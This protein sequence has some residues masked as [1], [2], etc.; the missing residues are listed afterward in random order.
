WQFR[1][2]E[3][4]LYRYRKHDGGKSNH[5]RSERFV[6]EF[7]QNR[8][9]Y[10]EHLEAVLSIREDTVWKQADDYEHLHTEFHRL[11]ANYRK[12]EEQF[13]KLSSAPQLPIRRQIARKV[14][15]LCKS[16][17]KKLLQA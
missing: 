8:S 16:K 13:N 2:V 9:L 5:Y 10:L 3:K 15:D 7:K 12:L 4:P 1:H 11:L 6:N 17:L 14:K